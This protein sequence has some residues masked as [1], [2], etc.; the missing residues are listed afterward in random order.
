MSLI[1]PGKGSCCT[2]SFLDRKVVEP[3]SAWKL[4][5]DTQ[6]L[7]APK[8]PSQLPWKQIQSVLCGHA[9]TDKEDQ[10][11]AA[12]LHKGLEHLWI[13]VSAG[14]T[15]TNPP[16]DTKG[17]LYMTPTADPNSTAWLPQTPKL[18]SPSS[19]SIL[20]QSNK[21]WPQL[22]GNLNKIRRLGRKL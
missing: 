16:M 15:A 9:S 1:S 18:S 4:P 5:W 2:R 19:S 14:D 20:L 22:T 10:L 11:S 8:C 3:R 7:M 13:L 21:L 12:I 17:W 6:S